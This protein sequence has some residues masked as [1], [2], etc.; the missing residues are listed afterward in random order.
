MKKNTVLIVDD[1]ER[2]RELL[3]LYLEQAGYA[4][5]E[6]DNGLSAML[7]IQQS[8]PDIIV[9]DV[10][11][12]VLDGLETC[13]QIRRISATPVI[14]LTARAE[15]ED[16]LLGFET[17]A[18]DYVAKP[19]SPG[20]VVARVQAIL[21]RTSPPEDLPPLSPAKSLL[22]CC[23]LEI[24]ASSR[25]VTIA[26]EEIELTAKEFDLLYTLASH[27]GRI[28][29]REALQNEVWGMG[30]VGDSRTVD[31]HVQRLRNKLQNGRCP[32]WNI[33]T[34]WGVGYRFDTLETQGHKP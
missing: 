33:S 32:D 28:H 19:F 25:T 14:L 4:V 26:G 31:V 2:I 17:G 1:D 24:N 15:D 10:M 5:L 16:K 9:L 30:V 3:R 7:S 29:T 21:R 13:R 6:A 20:E 34:V 22:S 18:D 12:P 8:R 11:M 23:R 27:P